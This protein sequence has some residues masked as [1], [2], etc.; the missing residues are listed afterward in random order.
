MAETYKFY[1]Y[2][3]R[4]LNSFWG[5]TNIFFTPED[6]AKN[7]FYYVTPQ[8]YVKCFSCG[9][10]IYEWP[11]NTTIEREHLRLS[12]DCRFANGIDT[13]DN[14][15]FDTP[16][17][18]QKLEEEKPVTYYVSKTPRYSKYTD[19]ENR[20]KSFEEWPIAIKQKSNELSECGF[21][22]TNRSDIVTCHFCGITIRNWLPED[23]PWVL[24]AKWSPDCGY[25]HN[26]IGHKFIS[27][28]ADKNP[29]IQSSRPGRSCKVCMDK[30]VSVLVMPCNHLATCKDCTKSR[31]CVICRRHIENTIPVFFS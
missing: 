27:I 29:A 11:A 31:R 10:E 18:V 14:V 30:D 8:N 26:T 6:L 23:N 19:I 16:T 17:E 1:R 21:F 22:Y 2:E 12:S 3:F 20:K 15:C 25:L 9:I 24:H 28:Y 4:R 7:G 5:W 13:C